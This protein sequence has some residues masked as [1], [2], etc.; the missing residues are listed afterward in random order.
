MRL[1]EIANM[2]RGQVIKN[3]SGKEYVVVGNGNDANLYFMVFDE[4]TLTLQNFCI[5]YLKYFTMKDEIKDIDTIKVKMQMLGR[6]FYIRPFKTLFTRIEKETPYYLS[7][8]NFFDI[9]SLYSDKKTLYYPATT[10]FFDIINLY[11]DKELTLENYP[12]DYEICMVFFKDRIEL[13]F[14]NIYNHDKNR[15][16]IDK[17][18]PENGFEK[19]MIAWS[20]DGYTCI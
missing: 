7:A 6:N 4:E 13:L 3:P 19:S 18:K 9:L 5:T 10:N 2:K 8:T 1:K 20:K 14:D 12:D 16:T 15:I 11:S 17:K